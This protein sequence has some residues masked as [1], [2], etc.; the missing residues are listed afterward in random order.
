MREGKE[1]KDNARRRLGDQ[2]GRV[3]LGTWTNG[4]GTAPWQE[5][6]TLSEQWRL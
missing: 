3:V 5:P 2:V 6:E 4:V 1:I